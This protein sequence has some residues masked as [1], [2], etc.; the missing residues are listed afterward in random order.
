MPR[1]A[2]ADSQNSQPAAAIGRQGIA[3]H[4]HRGCLA[5]RD[6]ATSREYFDKT[7]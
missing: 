6:F 4:R 2:P 1:K 3:L 7:R 5:F